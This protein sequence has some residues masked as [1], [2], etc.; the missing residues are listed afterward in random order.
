MK[1][2]LP[3]VNAESGKCKRCKRKT[4]KPVRYTYL[5]GGQGQGKR[6]LVHKGELIITNPRRSP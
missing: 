5:R 3:E 1:T 6:S 2:P 4:T